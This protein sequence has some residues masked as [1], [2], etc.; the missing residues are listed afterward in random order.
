MQ[1]QWADIPTFMAVWCAGA[2]AVRFVVHYGYGAR[3][4]HGGSVA[5]EGLVQLFIQ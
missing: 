5:V 4:R 3:G 2:P 1:H